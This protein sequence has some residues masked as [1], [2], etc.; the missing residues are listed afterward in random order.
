VALRPGAGVMHDTAHRVTDLALDDAGEQAALL[1]WLPI[2]Y[3]QLTAGPYRGHFR[4][5]AVGQQRIVSESQ[6]QTVLKQGVMA[7]GTC[8]VSFAATADVRGTFSEYPISTEV[9]YFCPERTEFDLRHSGTA[10]S[11]YFSFAQDDFLRDAVALDER[12]WSTRTRTFFAARRIGQLAAFAEALMQRLKQAHTPL[13]PG[14]LAPTI[15][16]NALAAF[17]RSEVEGPFDERNV[18]LRRRALRIVRRARDYID[19][20]LD[21][22][23][24][25]TIVD[26][27]RHA[28]VS[29]RSLQY[30]F[31]EALALTPIAYLRSARLHRARA[32]LRDGAAGLKVGDVAAR[33]GFWHLSKFAGDYQKL[34]GELPSDTL[35]RRRGR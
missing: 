7:P 12:Y 2:E 25:P 30:C 17:D 6:T 28:G 15:I 8:T 19:Q 29:Q 5:L 18:L 1:P 22:H 14:R 21:S 11:I 9:V 13:P 24:P 32:E 4:E 35:L 26:V 31:L 3:R 33:W 20:A 27:C 10:A 23:Q 34:F 16:A